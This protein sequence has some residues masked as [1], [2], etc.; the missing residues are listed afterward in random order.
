M[1]PGVSLLCILLCMIP[2][3]CDRVY[4]HP[5]HLFAYSHE[6]CKGLEEKER[7]VKTFVPISIESP[8]TPVYEES[9]RNK[10]EEGPQISGV[11]YLKDLTYV[12]GARI[13]RELVEMHKGENILLSPT[14]IYQ[15]LLIFYLGASGRTASELQ[16]LLGFAPPSI[17]Q[18]CTSK[19]DGHK[20]LPVLRTI[21]SPKE[22]D[23]LLFSKLFCLFSA[24]N[25]HLS[26]SFVHELT[27][28]DINFYVRAVDFTNP[29][30]AGEQIDAFVKS[31]N[32]H[33]SKSLLTDVDPA[34]NLLFATYTQFKAIVKGASLLNDPQEFWTNSETKI[35][36]PM[37]RVTGNFEHKFDNNLNLSVIKTAVSESVFLL[38]LQPINNEDLT[39]AETQYS[40]QPSYLW[41]QKLS[42]RRINLT[43]PTLSFESVYNLQDPLNKVG[44]SELLG[45]RANFSKMTD[46][47]LNARKIINQQLFELRPGKGDHTE[48]PTEQNE[49]TETLSI[50]LNKPFLLAVHEKESSALL[51]FGR[52][53][54]PLQ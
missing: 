24:P 30:R 37:M 12:L 1:N 28:A 39:G 50:T 45:K 43:L 16:G 2:V 54:N 38:L 31:K 51:Y 3:G 5:F 10:S 49:D 32:T 15:S 4:V 41:L 29:T 40:I 8:I 44:L 17:S 35:S 26:E 14:S 42:P 9:V 47:N 11:D 46:V 25:V 21:S 52:V 7:L 18:D 22:A 53:I 20:I 34:S 6:S 13:Y 36:V 48:N 27:F 19:I 23:E 33:T